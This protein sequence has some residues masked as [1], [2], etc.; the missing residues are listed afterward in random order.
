MDE[1]PQGVPRDLTPRAPASG[2]TFVPP[3]GN[4]QYPDFAI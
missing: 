1:R 3:V 4:F 2:L